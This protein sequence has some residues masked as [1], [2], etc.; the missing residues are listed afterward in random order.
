MGSSRSCGWRISSR[1]S[2]RNWRAM[3]VVG[4]GGVDQRGQR[5]RHGDGVALRDGAPF[6]LALGRAEAGF[7]Q[8]A[9]AW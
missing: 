2:G 4:V 6:R 7:D 5:G 1:A 9:R 8:R 3:R